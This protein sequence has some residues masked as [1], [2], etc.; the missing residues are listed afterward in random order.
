MKL[1]INIGGKYLS[2]SVFATNTH[3][4]LPVLLDFSVQD[5]E[6][7]NS[8]LITRV[9]QRGYNSICTHYQLDEVIV[10]PHRTS[11]S[12]QTVALE[13][14]ND[15]KAMKKK[16]LE[17]VN[18]PG[19]P[20]EYIT[21]WTIQDDNPEEDY[22]RV[23]VTSISLDEFKFIS[24]IMKLVGERKYKIASPYSNL[25][26]LFPENNSPYLLLQLGH[27]TT[28][29]YIIK[30][31]VCMSYR[32]SKSFSGIQLSNVLLTMGNVTLDELY[33]FKN[34]ASYYDLDTCNAT[35]ELLTFLQSDVHG[36]LEEY[37]KLD[38]TPVAEY[39]VIGGIANLDLE[40]F[41]LTLDMPM[42][43]YY[44]RL[45]VANHKQL[46]DSVR[47][48]LYES[49]CVILEDEE[50]TNFT[51]PKDKSIGQYVKM[52]CSFYDYAKIPLYIIVMCLLLSIGANYVQNT[53]LEDKVSTQQTVVS[54][55]QAEVDSLKSTVE[56]L[57]ATY[58]ELTD[59]KELAIVNYGE[60][61][62]VLSQVIPQGSFISEVKDITSEYIVPLSDTNL[63]GNST[64]LLATDTPS[65]DG[66][67]LPNT[68]S[69]TGL[70][71]GL[72]VSTADMLVALEINGYTN[73]SVKAYDYA[74]LLKEVFKDAV[75][76]SVKSDGTMYSF[77]IR[78]IINK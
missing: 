19:N 3:E 56:T 28:E 60:T 53:M 51:A 68:Q 76:S 55:Y 29:L 67:V 48:Y 74:L 30:N 42:K 23:L 33:S 73:Q 54:N 63:T 15:V 46:T 52:V 21:D 50:A 22:Q 1:V 6:G 34:N 7:K 40:T 65:T 12:I 37:S 78:V 5:I 64:D 43:R 20:G 38:S 47:N 70:I 14:L 9:I 26:Y 61:L 71:N 62:S 25:A 16:L 27:K 66:T 2:F 36:F 41:T 10:I 58:N 31:G 45:P 44:P 4:S 13:Y 69:S 72:D 8:N 75:V 32:Q 59:D 24:E 49:A 18:L 35:S 77:T 57:Q 17:Q 11:V 39:A